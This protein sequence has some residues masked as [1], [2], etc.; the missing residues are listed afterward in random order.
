MAKTGW[1]TQDIMQLDYSAL[2]TFDVSQLRQMTIRIS[3]YAN[4]RIAKLEKAGMKEFSPAHGVLK[5]GKKKGKK[6]GRFGVRGIAKVNDER[7]Q[8]MMYIN[9]IQRAQSFIEAP[10]STVKGAKEVRK[11]FEKEHGEISAKDYDR[12]WKLYDEIR[13]RGFYQNV[14]S[15]VAVPIIKQVVEQ[16]RKS[17]FK[18]RL[19]IAEDA[20]RRVNEEEELMRNSRSKDVFD[21]GSN[22]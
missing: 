5:K 15:D 3:D 9:E 16:N 19:E 10:T 4:K 17:A 14:K 22:R 12:L 18:K 13:D 8:R 6:K 1:K 21:Y 7:K 11:Q 20:L 2:L